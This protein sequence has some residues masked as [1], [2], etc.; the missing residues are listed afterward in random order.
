MVDDLWQAQ[1]CAAGGQGCLCGTKCREQE[2]EELTVRYGS[3]CALKVRRRLG[4]NVLAVGT[5][6][7]LAGYGTRQTGNR[8]LSLGLAGS[9]R[10]GRHWGPR[11]VHNPIFDFVLHWPATFQQSRMEVGRT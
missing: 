8:S 2:E 3:C 11:R 6:Q 7:Y 5:L 1:Q 9:S 4:Y 10:L